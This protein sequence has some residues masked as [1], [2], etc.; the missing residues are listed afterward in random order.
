MDWSNKTGQRVRLN[1]QVVGLSPMPPKVSHGAKQ[2]RVP[3]CWWATLGS[4]KEPLRASLVII[5]WDVWSYPCT[6]NFVRFCRIKWRRGAH[7]I[8]SGGDTASQTLSQ[9]H[10]QRSQGG[11]TWARRRRPSEQVPC[12]A[13]H[14]V[15]LESAF[16]RAKETCRDLFIYFFNYAFWGL[17]P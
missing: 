8:G 2:P 5:R 17:F 6:G 7:L 10:N 16:E 11:G 9:D 15:G 3:V 1:P 12:P 4:A 14:V 13:A